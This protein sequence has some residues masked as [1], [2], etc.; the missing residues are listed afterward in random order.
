M[1]EA[2]AA[3][4][5]ERLLRELAEAVAPRSACIPGPVAGACPEL[6]GVA[7]EL[8]LE[9]TSAPAGGEDIL[10]LLAGV[11]APEP[12]PAVER[13]AAAPYLLLCGPGAGAGAE[14][15]QTDGWLARRGG[16]DADAVLL[17]PAARVLDAPGLPGEWHAGRA[18][19]QALA[20]ER[21]ALE[22]LWLAVERDREAL[23]TLTER[24]EDDARRL[25]EARQARERLSA[26]VARLRA[27]ERHE[28]DRM[29]LALVEQRAWVADQA[30]RVAA[31]TSWRLGHRLVRIG[32]ALAFKRDRG[33]DLPKRI[34]E[35]MRDGEPR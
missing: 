25:D 18:P 21:E 17:A 30:G 24:T 6:A 19:A 32:R 5:A 27:A 23:V 15:F 12:H 2:A 14:R 10:C 13:F 20:T 34:A 7:R 31:S 3:P 1:S 22:A 4:A 35:R 29:R 33:T 9:V 8:G 11:D 16:A 26:E 28:L